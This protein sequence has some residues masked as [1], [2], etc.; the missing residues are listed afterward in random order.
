MHP[1]YTRGMRILIIGAGAREHAILDAVQRSGSGHEVFVAPGNAGMEGIAE[2]V[3]FPV[4]DIKGL[5]DFAENAEIELTI[6]GPEVPL[7]LGL[8]DEFKRRDLMIFGPS[9]AAS[10]VEG[11][12]VFTKEFCDRHSIPTAPFRVF[13]DAHA[14]IDYV[15]QKNTFPIVLK[16]DGLA[17]GKG[18]IIPATFAEAEVAIKSMMEEGAFGEAGARIVIED[19][20]PG[21]EASL[22]C[23]TD[24]K[25]VFP[26]ITAQDHKRV[27]DG[28]VGPNT[29]GMGCYAPAPVATAEVIAKAMK[30]IIEPSVSGLARENR[31]FTGF[32]YA[33]LMIDPAGEPRLVE[34]NCR[35]GDPECE[36]ILPM[37]KSDFVGLM[38]ACC[39]GELAQYTFEWH[40]GACV[41]VVLAAEGYPGKVR[42]DDVISG[43]DAAPPE[44]VKVFHAGTALNENDEIVTNGGRVLCVS[45]RASDLKAAIDAAY[46]HVARISWQGMHFRKD[47][48]MKGLKRL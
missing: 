24:G 45:A 28:D 38:L 16:A 22:I 6:V 48:G 26:L 15:R 37:L 43:L 13:Y 8:V 33:G 4:D 3:D 34:Y 27:G 31:A 11:S 40:A 10:I 42:K 36:V 30:K 12:K 23:I 14:A 29:G 25:S 47:I 2:C 44:N 9:A 18:V 19:F 46:A 39:R 5:A 35:M 41:C 20:M 7:V 1:D 32:L 21:E 17:A